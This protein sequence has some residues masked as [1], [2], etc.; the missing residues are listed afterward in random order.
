MKSVKKAKAQAAKVPQMLPHVVEELLDLYN[1]L[2]I[3]ESR[4]KVLVDMLAKSLGDGNHVYKDKI[5]CV[6]SYG[7]GKDT[8]YEMAFSNVDSTYK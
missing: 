5:L 6:R 4:A 3:S 8:E 1:D 2:E 7:T